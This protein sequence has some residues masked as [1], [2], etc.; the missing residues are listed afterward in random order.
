[1]KKKSEDHETLSLL[2]TRDGEPY[3]MIVDGSKEQVHGEFRQ[4]AQEANCHLKQTE[5]FSPWSNAAKGMIQELKKGIA[6]KM[7]Q[8]PALKSLIRSHTAHDIYMLNGE[9]PEIIVSGQTTNIPEIAEFWWY[10]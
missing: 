5:P 6:R 3:V 2:F 1:M 4:K 8:I 9:V 7:L 10:K